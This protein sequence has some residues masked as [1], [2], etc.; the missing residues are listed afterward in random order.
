MA[1]TADPPIT[2]VLDPDDDVACLEQ[3]RCLHSRPYGQ[4]LCEPDPTATSRGVALHL[5][6]ALGKY[7]DAP[8]ET[9]PWPLV[10]CHLAAEHVHDLAVARA[11]TLSYGALRQLAESTRTAHSRLWLIS[12]GEQPTSAIA[13]LLEA[14]P[15]N[16]STL[17]TLLDRWRAAETAPEADP[18]P[19][20]AGADFP[21]LTPRG[22]DEPLTRAALTR[23]LPPAA[24]RQ[25]RNAW[26]QAREWATVWL[27]N[28]PQASY[29]DVADSVYRLAASADSASELLIRALAALDAL[30]RA[31]IP[32]NRDV[33]KRDMLWEW[34]ETRPYQWRDVIARA[35][36]LADRT[37]SPQL[38]ALIA[39]R[40][41][42]RSPLSAR[43][44]TLGGVM[45]DGAITSIWS[46]CC[47][48]PPQLRRALAT[49]RR[50]LVQAGA[51]NQDPMLPGGP[52]GRMST[53]AIENALDALDAPASMWTDGPDIRDHFDGPAFD[54]RSIL[55]WLNPLDL[56][57]DP[58]R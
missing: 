4:V 41:I 2:L 53:Q 57:D 1:R 36:Q 40:A 23:G 6:E 3:L 7:T 9:S 12:V 21:H 54:G 50:Q 52:W 17:S 30:R 35:A 32:V 48:V 47:A 8:T 34:G 26:D 13:Q 10:S 18:T 56:F 38:A 22:S 14:R 11:H 46:S 31:G 29:Q 19:P 51:T 55:H 33:L 39:V 44:V 27:A 28:H 42:Y 5:L 45:P 25:A 16:R 20:G 49:Q 43:Q 15:Q 37:V 24:G 58:G